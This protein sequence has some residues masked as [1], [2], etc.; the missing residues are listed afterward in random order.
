MNS[1]VTCLCHTS[2]IACCSGDRVRVARSSQDTLRVSSSASGASSDP[3]TRAAWLFRHICR[4][5]AKGA[6][7]HAATDTCPILALAISGHQVRHVST[8]PAHLST[9]RSPMPG[10]GAGRRPARRDT[11][12]SCPSVSAG[13]AMR[14]AHGG[15]PRPASSPQPPDRRPG[16]SKPRRECLDS[17]CQQATPRSSCSCEGACKSRVGR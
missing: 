14:H 12:S 17:G 7:R 16:R 5:A 1:A 11:A 13:P 10:S 4:D 15:W 9:G 6:R 2:S 8:R 3:A